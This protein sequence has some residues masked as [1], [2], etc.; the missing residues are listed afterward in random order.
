MNDINNKHSI[1]L[2]CCMNYNLGN[3]ITNYAL[4]KY[5]SNEGY[6]VYVANLGT[7]GHELLDEIFINN[8]YSKEIICS[9]SKSCFDVSFFN[10]KC[11]CFV[12]GSDQVLRYDFINKTNYYTC[13]NWVKHS[14]NKIAYASSFGVDH[15]EGDVTEVEKTKYFLKRFNKISVRE[16]SGVDI[17]KNT[18]GIEG[19]WVLDPVFLPK[20][21]IYNELA[22]NGTERIPREPFVGSYILDP[23]NEK[24]QLISKCSEQLT[25][26]NN[27][28]VLDF[29]KYREGICDI[30]FNALGNPKIEEW[31]AMIKNCDFFI[32]DSFHGMCMALIFNKQF[33]IVCD[34]E[35]WRGI[36][37]IKSLLEL[38]HIEGRLIENTNFLDVEELIN[39]K[40]D[41]DE[42]NTILRSRQVESKQWLRAAM[43]ETEANR[44]YSFEDFV[45]DKFNDVN[46]KFIRYIDSEINKVKQQHYL[47]ERCV[48]NELF[49]LQRNKR[50]IIIDLKKIRNG[51]M[52]IIGWG[53][54]DCFKRNYNR[55]KQFYNLKWVCD[56]NPEKWGCEIADGVKCI[57]PKTLREM[58]DVLVV[59]MVDNVGASFDIANKLLEMGI[60]NFDHIDNWI[61]FVENRK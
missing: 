6:N 46:T 42:I 7:I 22:A 29:A 51:N 32:T 9:A 36:T 52:E 41:Y 49:I 37:R 20:V 31:I 14:K 38:L 8:P 55:I 24:L 60:C 40:I 5:L 3:N 18:F 26:Y 35:N 34:K 11:D 15:F 53:A 10:D 56:N 58:Q 4:Y 27:L 44:E 59:I 2:A 47:S 54:G 12:L 25:N 48:R 19:T 50:N 1:E 39:K 61:K 13:L 43:E 45:Y 57:S 23:S 17:L 16:N 28:V 21:D 30:D 33:Y